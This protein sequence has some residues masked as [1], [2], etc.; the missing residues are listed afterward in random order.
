MRDR[1]NCERQHELKERSEKIKGILYASHQMFRN[2]FH[3]AGIHGDASDAAGRAHHSVE[4]DRRGK[5]ARDWSAHHARG[6]DRHG[7]CDGTASA[8][9]GDDCRSI[10]RAEKCAG[11]PAGVEP[12]VADGAGVEDALAQRRSD[13]HARD[14]GAEKQRPADAEQDDGTMVAKKVQTLAH[15]APEALELSFGGDNVGA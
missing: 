10:E 2:H 15:L 1:A 11:A 12:S 13:D 6:N 8:Q 14:H 7:K 3:Q 5:P 4:Q 9:A